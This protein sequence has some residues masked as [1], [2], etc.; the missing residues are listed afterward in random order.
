MEPVEG[1]AMDIHLGTMSV[2]V[3]IPAENAEDAKVILQQM[4]ESLNIE[5]Q[6]MSK[7]ENRA[8]LAGEVR[9]GSVNGMPICN[10]TLE[11]MTAQM[12]MPV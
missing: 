9:A 7:A 3:L 12:E 8:S 4:A 1:M 11:R 2:K 10:T 6:S 5:L